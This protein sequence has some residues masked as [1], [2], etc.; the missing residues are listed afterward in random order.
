MSLLF[1]VNKDEIQA[2]K[3]TDS[4]VDSNHSKKL[5]V[6]SKL[7]T[8]DSVGKITKPRRIYDVS[9]SNEEGIYLKKRNITIFF[10]YIL[11][12]LIYLKP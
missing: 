2:S 11:V 5:K 10:L 8:D 12:H 6:K 4:S 7:F 3:S 9:S 1:T